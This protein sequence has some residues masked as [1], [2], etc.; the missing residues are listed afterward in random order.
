MGKELL[1]GLLLGVGRGIEGF[2]DAKER[3]RQ[4]GREERRDAIF[5]QQA[6]QRQR[7]SDL[8][9]RLFELQFQELGLRVKRAE[10]DRDKRLALGTA[11]EQ[12]DAERLF[13]EEM[14][15]L[16]LEAQRVE[17][18][19]KE[20]RTATSKATQE[21]TE[22]R[23]RLLGIQDL[24]GGK[25]QDDTKELLASLKNEKRVLEGQL[26]ELG[27]AGAAND[28]LAQKQAEIEFINDR[29]VGIERA[30]QEGLIGTGNFPSP[31]ID[32]LSSLLNPD[33]VPVSSAAPA[34]PKPFGSGEPE[35]PPQTPF[36]EVQSGPELVQ[37][38]GGILSNLLKSGIR[39]ATSLAPGPTPDPFAKTFRVVGT[40]SRV[41]PGQMT[42]EQVKR[43]LEMGIIEDIPPPPPPADSF[44]GP[45]APFFLQGTF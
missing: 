27:E 15:T 21:N 5:E 32:A 22:E 13:D 36:F 7:Q 33:T 25:T 23:T 8:D 34:P 9:T 41:Q 26:N 19:L 43:A 24:L 38:S 12:A 37:R 40:D 20:Q 42:Q 39:G 2:A 6:E 44:R 4:A 14:N 30:V 17:I 1:G 10:F 31:V 28:Q 45:L 3:Q 16:D 18:A 35:K 29:I 11:E